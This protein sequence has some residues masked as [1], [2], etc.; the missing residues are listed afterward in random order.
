M[1]PPTLLTLPPEIRNIIFDMVL[2]VPSGRITLQRTEPK[3]LDQPALLKIRILEKSQP[4]NPGSATGEISLSFLRA[5][6]Q[7]YTECKDL[8]WTRN[9]FVFRAL[10]LW[11]DISV[12]SILHQLTLSD[13]PYR[14]IVHLEMYS[15][16]GQDNVAKHFSLLGKW[17]RQ[18]AALES[19]TV[20]IAHCGISGTRPYGSASQGFFKLA[21][22]DSVSA[23]QTVIPDDT[24]AALQQLDRKLVVTKTFEDYLCSAFL[25]RIK[26]VE[27][28]QEMHK[29]FGGEMWVG[30][31]LWWKMA[32]RFLPKRPFVHRGVGSYVTDD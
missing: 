18:G 16:L 23:V 21:L 12:Q 31:K 19:L 24:H 32:S 26:S 14:H 28:V 1:M 6:K 4:G 30:E 5:C 17:I 11:V 29:A 2:V 8:L 25:G 15:D 9:T 3:T 7:I 20:K 22:I 27:I 10:A 13:P